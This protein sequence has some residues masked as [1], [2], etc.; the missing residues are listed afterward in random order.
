MKI[1][2]I[3]I[4]FLT[5][6][7]IIFP[8]T[9]SVSAAFTDVPDNHPYKDEIDFC[10][11]MG[12]VIGENATAFMPDLKLT[13]AHFAIIWCRTL[14]IK[15]DNHNF[16]DITSLKQYFDGPAIV[17]NSLGLFK[18]TSESIFAPE[19][20]ITREQLALITMRTYNLGVANPEAYQQYA[21]HALIS[22]WARNGVSSCI[23]ANVFRNLYNG[24]NFKPNEPVTRAEIC[25]LIY[26]IMPVY[27]VTIGTLVGGTITASPVK[28]HSGSLITLTITPDEGKQLKAGT[29]KYNDVNITGTTFIMPSK[30][31]TITAE[32]ENKPV[33]ITSI[34]ITD[35]VKTTYNVGVTKVASF[36][37]TVN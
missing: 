24:E 2:K 18:G 28:P 21:D 10:K 16:S 25:K 19:D 32:F 29:L 26:N 5:V 35:P 31:V 11:A 13:R 23:N 3:L 17:L 37:V 14:N 8:L 34:T 1:K 7:I 22:D 12:F 33:V 20:Y 4:M 30:N 27:K 15:D 9:I 6:A 36:D